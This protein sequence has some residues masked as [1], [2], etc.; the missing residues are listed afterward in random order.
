MTENGF[1][2]KLGFS[3]P[4]VQGLITAL[5]SMEISI[6]A[7]PAETSTF[8]SENPLGND[9]RKCL[10]VTQLIDELEHSSGVQ[11]TPV[12]EGS[13]GLLA[14]D[15]FNMRQMSNKV[16]VTL[17]CRLYYFWL[18]LLEW[19]WSNY[20]STTGCRL[21]LQSPAGTSSFRMSR[22]APQPV[23]VCHQLVLVIVWSSSRG[24]IYKQRWRSSSSVRAFNR[25]GQSGGGCGI[26]R[27]LTLDKLVS[28]VCFGGFVQHL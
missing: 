19:S 5:M 17:L 12:S 13:R 4:E 9:G 10:A 24:K 26:S 7:F 16:E 21:L 25:R 2:A 18:E 20:Y 11:R 3:T 23:S 1:S 6:A 27:C 14:G 15:E 28:V 8:T 22:R